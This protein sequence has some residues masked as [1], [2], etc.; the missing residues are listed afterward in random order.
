MRIHVLDIH[1]IGSMLPGTRF[2]IRKDIPKQ[3][4]KF[5]FATEDSGE[6]ERETKDGWPSYLHI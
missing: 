6:H 1:P 4:V 3:S 2:R 5:I